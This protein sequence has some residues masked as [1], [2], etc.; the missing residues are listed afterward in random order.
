VES[1]RLGKRTCR[2]AAVAARSPHLSKVD[3]GLRVGRQVVAARDL[4]SRF[5]LY[6]TV[7]AP[8]P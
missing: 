4:L 3:E 2:A 8:A 1:D 7:D 5:V 6:D